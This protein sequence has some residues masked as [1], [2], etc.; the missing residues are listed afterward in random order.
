MSTLQEREKIKMGVSTCL[1]GEKVRYDGG[2][3]LDRYIRDTLGQFFSYVPVCPEVE[4]GLPV[5]REALHL[6]GDPAAPRLVTVRTGVDHTDG[7]QQWAEMRLDGLSHE[8][9]SGFIF[10][11]RSPSSGLKGVKVYTREGMPGGSASGIF[12]AAFRRRNPLVPAID[13]GRLND[14]VLREQFIDAVFIY[15][16]W[17]DFARQSNRIGDLVAFHTEMKLL[18]MAHSPRHYSLLGRLTADIKDRRPDEVRNSYAALLM[19]AAGLQATRKKH[20][21][22]LL[23][24]LGYFKKQLTSDEKSELIEIIENYRKEYL[25]LIVPVTLLN[26]YVRKYDEKYLKRQRYLNPYPLELA[27]RNHV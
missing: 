27:L 1:L 2:H 10:K 7:M 22:V 11:S 17:Q 16:H 18:V 24:C 3:K 12:A 25:P 8:N 21:N 6:V 26:H 5:P 4:Y 19:E 20:S 15:R 23:H 13:E 14:A 9:L